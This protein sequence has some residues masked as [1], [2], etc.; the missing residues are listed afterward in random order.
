LF[1]N[2]YSDLDTKAEAD[3]DTDIELADTSED[4]SVVLEHESDAE[5]DSEA[6]EIL[7]DIA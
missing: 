6:K 4:T 2:T 3:T 5:F 1:S 7:N